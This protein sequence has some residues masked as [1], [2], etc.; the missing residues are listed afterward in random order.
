VTEV[1]TIW[2]YI[3][4]IIIII[5]TN[6][7]YFGGNLDPGTDTGTFKGYGLVYCCL[8]ALSAQ[9]GYTVPCRST[10]YIT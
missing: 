4:L 1:M 9:T 2:R 3:N 8:T 7:K 6:N 5:I 10:M